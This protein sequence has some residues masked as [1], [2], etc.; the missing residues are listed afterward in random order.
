VPAKISEKDIGM[1]GVHFLKKSGGGK[2]QFRCRV[3]LFGKNVVSRCGVS[4]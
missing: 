4:E 1:Y 2:K 3:M